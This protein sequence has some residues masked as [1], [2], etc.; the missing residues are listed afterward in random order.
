M[1]CLSLG[2]MSIPAD[3]GT[4][5]RIFDSVS[6]QPGK[7]PDNLL[8][9]EFRLVPGAEEASSFSSGRFQPTK[10][11]DSGPEFRDPLGY[12]IA[13]YF[14]GTLASCRPDMARVYSRRS[15]S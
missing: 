7:P 2:S 5:L 11:S 13:L 10:L 12:H 14:Q 6:R 15:I 9:Y 4:G 1:D 8:S 3:I